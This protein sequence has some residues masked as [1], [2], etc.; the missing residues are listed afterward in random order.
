MQGSELRKFID[1][2]QWVTSA[3]VLDSDGNVE[4]PRLQVEISPEGHETISEVG[5]QAF[6][7]R[8]LAKLPTADRQQNYLK[9]RHRHHW[10]LDRYQSDREH[11]QPGIFS[12]ISDLTEH[13][14]LFD[15]SPE[16]VFFKGHFPGNPI[17]PGIAQLHW[18][19]AVTMSLF[20]FTEVPNGIKRLKFKKIVQPSTVLELLLKKK[21]EN[22]VEF[23]FVSPAQV[24]S[25][26]SLTFKEGLS[27]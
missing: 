5:F 7:K 6:S 16:M 4:A 3:V 13:R 25:M 19:A 27:C 11:R 18:A 17:L 9:F 2:N 14:L 1:D 10:I 8:L 21:S 24:H 22:E 26:G 12:W 15:V 20:N 23:Q